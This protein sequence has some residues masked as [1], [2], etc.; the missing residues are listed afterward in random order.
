MDENQEEIIMTNED[1]T[2]AETPQI[3]EKFKSVGQLVNAYRQLEGAYTKK[4]QE[5]SQLQATTEKAV[6]ELVAPPPQEEQAAPYMPA[7]E[8][9]KQALRLAAVRE[10]LLQIAQGAAPVVVDR[11]AGVPLTPRNR[12]RSLEEAGRLAQQG[13]FGE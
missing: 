7:T 9:E 5:L 4:C 2:Q 8:E 3:P 6:E 10:Y 12:P 11:H 1:E 13:Y